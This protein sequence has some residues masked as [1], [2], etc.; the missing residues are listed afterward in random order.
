MASPWSFED[1]DKHVKNYETNKK[2]R[3]KIIGRVGM[4]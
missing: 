3:G 2:W 1:V 4:E